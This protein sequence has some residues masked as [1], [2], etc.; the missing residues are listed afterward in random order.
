M[1]SDWMVQCPAREGS[2]GRPPLPLSLPLLQPGPADARHATGIKLRVDVVSVGSSAESA[3]QQW[4]Q[5]LGGP[6]LRLAAPLL[7]AAF[8]LLAS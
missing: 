2:S 5:Q 6:W 3:W 1:Y 7:A 4:K 8:V